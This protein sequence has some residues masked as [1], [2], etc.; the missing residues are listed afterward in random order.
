MTTKEKLSM[1]DSLASVLL[2]NS[3]SVQV[4]ILDVRDSFGRTDIL[5][6]PVCGSGQQWVDM[7]RVQKQPAGPVQEGAQ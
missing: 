4:K 7:Q 5:V 2:E 3:L 1:I 6:T